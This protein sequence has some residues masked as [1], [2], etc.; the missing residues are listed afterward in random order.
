MLHWLAP[1]RRLHE[2]D[3]QGSLDE[4]MTQYLTGWPGLAGLERLRLNVS[5]SRQE[6]VRRTL[7]G[8][9]YHNPATVV[10]M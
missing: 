10:T 6:R 3:L 5:P 7:Q 2:L 9:A 1:L 8:S 4:E